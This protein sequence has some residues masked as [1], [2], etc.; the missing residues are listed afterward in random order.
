LLKQKLEY[1]KQEIQNVDIETQNYNNILDSIINNC[2]V[3]SNTDNENNS[4]TDNENNSNTDNKKKSNDRKYN[5][6]TAIN[7]LNT[8]NKKI[9]GYIEEFN[10]IYNQNVCVIDEYH[11]ENCDILSNKIS[12]I[13]QPS[14]GGKNKKKSTKYHKKSRKTI[15][16]NKKSRKNK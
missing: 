6:Y 10:K 15:K 9:I 3:Y 11:K 14:T 7:L 12:N 13:I 5:C 16:K 2:S 1:I 8:K 4:N